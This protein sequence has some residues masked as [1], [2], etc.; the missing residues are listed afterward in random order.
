M[1]LIFLI[2]LMCPIAA[3]AI[4]IENVQSYETSLTWES[5][6]V[7]WHKTAVLSHEQFFRATHGNEGESYVDFK[8]DLELPGRFT[9]VNSLQPLPQTINGN[10]QSSDLIKTMVIDL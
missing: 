6:Y 8:E 10:S 5:I 3:E 7:P 9:W 2:V 1:W 4:S